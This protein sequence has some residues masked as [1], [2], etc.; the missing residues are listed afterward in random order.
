[1]KRDRLSNPW[2]SIPAADYEGHMGSPGV[3][4]L[5]FLSRIFGELL[6]EFEPRAV[7]VLGCATGNGFER[8][9]AGRI[10]RLVGL[11]INREYLELCR[12]RH[13][14]KIPGLELA[15]E[16][17]VSFELEP[18]SVDFV[19]AA[20]FLEYVD[21]ALVIEK[22]SRWLKSRGT[23]ATVLQLPSDSCGTVSDTGFTSLK[24]LE[25]VIHLVEPGYLERILQRRGFSRVRSG[26]ETLEGG[27]DFFVGV[28]RLEAS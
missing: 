26:R 9:E 15:C 24:T 7:A 5:E 6:A 21:P 12:E 18:R 3:R 25:P 22:A 23:F 8:V 16:D 28:Y 11:D 20:L 10:R 17:V 13:A 2:L 27:K 14:E 4:Q 19:H 1:M